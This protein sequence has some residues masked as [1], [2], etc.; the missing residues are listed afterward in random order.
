MIHN[1]F[2]LLI[3]L[4]DT[5]GLVR[6]DVT[7]FPAFCRTERHFR[8]SDKQVFDKWKLFMQVYAGPVY[9]SGATGYSWSP[10]RLGVRQHAGIQG[11]GT[12]LWR[13]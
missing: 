6:Y 4:I 8:R 3:I 13:H 2:N 9:E 11:Q 5:N 1:I 7:Y 10:A 12:S